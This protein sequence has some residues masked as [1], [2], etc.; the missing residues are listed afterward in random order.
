MRWK[1]L[2]SSHFFI[3][4]RKLDA[5]EGERNFL[6]P[7]WSRND[8]AHELYEV[9]ASTAMLNTVNLKFIFKNLSSF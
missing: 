8:D 4:F 9:R 6:F 5:A 2:P 7:G 1:I 3:K